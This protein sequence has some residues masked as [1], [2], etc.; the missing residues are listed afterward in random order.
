MKRSII[1]LFI[2]PATVFAHNDGITIKHVNTRAALEYNDDLS[3][4]KT[5]MNVESRNAPFLLNA[6]IQSDPTDTHL[7]SNLSLIRINHSYPSI[8]VNQVIGYAAVG[9]YGKEG[10]S[11]AKTFFK[12]QKFGVCEYQNMKI[13]GVKIDDNVLSHEIN[14]KPTIISSYGNSKDGY[15]YSIE[16]FDENSDKTVIDQTISCAMPS[17]NES[18]IS[19]IIELGKKIDRS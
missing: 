15:L 9:A 1:S 4:P 13:E 16:W 12:D 19:N 14:D 6:S 7:K 2:I 10:W 11:G 17:K 18:V 8:P 5:L 3:Y